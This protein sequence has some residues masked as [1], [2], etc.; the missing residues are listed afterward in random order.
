MLPEGFEPAIPTMEPPQT[1]AVDRAATAIELLD[2]FT[3]ISKPLLQL[4][5]L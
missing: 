3:V 2:L 4:L 5:Y 1:H